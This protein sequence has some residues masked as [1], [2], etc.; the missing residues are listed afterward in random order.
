AAVT[1]TSTASA[2]DVHTVDLALADAS[3][4][5]SKTKSP[6][7]T[8]SKVGIIPF[9]WVKNAQTGNP[10][11]WARLV[12]VT[13]PQLRVALS[14]GTKLAL[15]TGNPADSRY[16][17]VSGRDNNS[18]TRVNALADTGYGI[19]TL[20]G[21]ASI[22]GSSGAPTLGTLGNGGQSSGGTLA[23]TMTY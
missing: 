4:A 23:T 19:R 12:N 10:A 9:I 3:Q 22:G 16:V 13:D 7:L 21:Q 18:G 6:Q 17:Y 14:G 15:I 8:G 1:S 20:V 2:T 5:A 11:D